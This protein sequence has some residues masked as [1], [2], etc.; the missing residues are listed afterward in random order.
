MP[1]KLNSYGG[2][3]RTTLGLREVPIVVVGHHDAASRPQLGD[4][5]WRRSGDPFSDPVDPVV[6]MAHDGSSTV[7]AAA[8]GR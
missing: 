4:L 6:A 7:P 2:R 5:G 8:K 1:V 3:A